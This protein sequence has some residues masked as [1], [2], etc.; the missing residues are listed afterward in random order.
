MVSTNLDSFDLA[1]LRALQNNGR[2]SIQEIA[3]AVGLSPSP[4]ARRLR[5]LEDAG[6]VTGYS[7]LIDEASLGFGFSVFLSVKLEKQVDDALARFE[8]A[9]AAHPE[10]VDCWLMTGNRDYMLRIATS[11]LE[12]FERF[13]VGTFTKIPGVAS[14]ESS[15]PLRRVKSGQARLG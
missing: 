6:V 10:I 13:L 8:R 9:I 15:I 3:T 11:G 1:I 5:L 2:A 4:V 7:A 14:I 12:E